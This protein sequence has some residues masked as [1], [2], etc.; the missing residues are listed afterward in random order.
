MGIVDYARALTPEKLEAA[1]EA[2]LR[3]IRASRRTRSSQ[4]H[5]LAQAHAEEK[6]VLVLGA[7]V[8]QDY[9]LPTWSTLL[10]QLLI[11]SI[12]TPDQDQTESSALAE[13][14][15]EIFKPNPLI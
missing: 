1:L 12:N 14:Y 2:T 8:S 4:L 9:N 5:N 11:E 13:I 7:G 6:L 10:Q 15:T 3:T